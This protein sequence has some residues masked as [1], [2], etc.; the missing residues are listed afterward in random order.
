MSTRFRYDSVVYYVTDLDQAVKFYTDVLGLPMSSRDAV[1]RLEMD[2][3]VLEL[4]CTDDRSLLSGK[5]NAR[6][7]LAVE[8]IEAAAADLLT[9]RVPVTDVREEGGGRVASLLDPEGNEILLREPAEPASED[10]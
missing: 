6:L 7:T 2:G 8:D 9:R 10:V 3:T 5:G 1:A 4:V